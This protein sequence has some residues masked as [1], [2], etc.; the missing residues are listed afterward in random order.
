MLPIQKIKEDS[1]KLR[2][3]VKA[4]FLG[5]MVGAF[6][7]IVGLAWN[8]AIK[9]FI[10]YWFPLSGSGVIIKFFY[11]GAI[12]LLLVLVSYYLIGSDSKNESR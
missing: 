2:K 5:Y 1:G 12:T 11:A 9:A 8:D 7:L 6:G 4:R 3:E 10:E